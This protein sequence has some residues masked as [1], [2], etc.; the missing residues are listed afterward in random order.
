M[1][2]AAFLAAAATATA[3]AGGEI[4]TGKYL[5]IGGCI[6][7]VFLVVYFLLPKFYGKGKKR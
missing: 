6:I 3:K 4:T 7:A 5:L 2:N 1:N